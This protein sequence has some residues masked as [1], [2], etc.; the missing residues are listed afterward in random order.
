MNDIEGCDESIG[1]KTMKKRRQLEVHKSTKSK[2][3]CEFIFAKVLT[4]ASLSP[5]DEKFNQLHRNENNRTKLKKVQSIEHN[6]NYLL[7]Y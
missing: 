4:Q 2:R 1:A 6:V 3:K 5:V 7:L